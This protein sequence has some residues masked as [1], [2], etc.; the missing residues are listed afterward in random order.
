[1]IRGSDHLKLGL[2]VIGGAFAVIQD[3]GAVAAAI[4]RLA[5]HGPHQGLANA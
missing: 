2:F 1:M 4:Q 5:R 3:T